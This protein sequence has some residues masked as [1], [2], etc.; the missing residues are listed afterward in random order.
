M[1]GIYLP[2]LFAVALL[3]SGC[4]TLSE[5]E[6]D[7]ADWRTIG[8]EDGSGGRLVTYVGNH[9]K[10]CADYGVK[11]DLARYQQGHAEGLIHFCTGRTGFRYGSSG[12]AYNG[13]CPAELEGDFLL[14]YERGR[15]LYQLRQDLRQLSREK[16][17]NEA[18]LGDV[19][20]RIADLE[21]LLISKQGSV[22]E[23]Q[24]WIEELRRQEDARGQL[25]EILHDLE[26][27]AARTERKYQTLSAR[28]QY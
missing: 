7:S 15:E 13:V 22:A 26:L 4:A 12:R 2:L 25:E 18:E 27:T 5:S 11:P 1:N 9:R 10:A 20:N 23:R 28:Y 19:S 8:F 24:G 3:G 17:S 21:S 6:C 16:K 14:A